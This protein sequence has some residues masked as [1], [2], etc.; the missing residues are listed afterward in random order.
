MWVA[1]EGSRE[2]EGEPVYRGSLMSLLR[3]MR[4]QPTGPS[5]WCAN[6]SQRTRSGMKRVGALNQ[7][8]FPASRP[9]REAV[10]GAFRPVTF[11]A[12][13]VLT[14]TCSRAASPQAEYGKVVG[15]LQGKALLLGTVV[16]GIGG[17][18]RWWIQ[19]L[20]FHWADSSNPRPLPLETLL[21]CPHGIRVLCVAQ[22]SLSVLAHGRYFIS[23]P[24]DAGFPRAV[25]AHPRLS[26]MKTPLSTYGLQVL[27]DICANFI[28]KIS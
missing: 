28:T 15:T 4:S 10:L 19:V 12:P 8:H 7:L 16:T 21:S 3:T 9:A 23:A 26:H 6:G 24:L 5:G 13:L 14:G 11:P 2:G 22:K 20:I 25:K 17:W 18:P 27:I 1:G